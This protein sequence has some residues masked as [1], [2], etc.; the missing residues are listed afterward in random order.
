MSFL[1]ASLDKARRL[2]ACSDGWPRGREHKHVVRRLVLEQLEGRCL[3]SY[4]IT[5][6]GTL[7][8]VSNVANGINSSG[9]VVGRSNDHAFLWDSVNRIQDLGTLG[10]FQ[11]EA[12]GINASDHVVG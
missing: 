7:G 3:L 2:M 5:D 1:N 10:G 11:S 4:S 6:L 9:H 8:G 12:F